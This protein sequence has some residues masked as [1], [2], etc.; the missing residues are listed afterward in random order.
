M[1]ARLLEAKYTKLSGTNAKHLP[2]PFK[3]RRYYLPSEV[4]S[5][6]T[7][8]DCWLSFFNQVYDMSKVIQDNYGALVEP[9]IQFAG[10]DITHWFDSNTKQV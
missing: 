3:L 2:K 8:T 4:A 7:P 10:A 6:N 1:A 9:I 5:H